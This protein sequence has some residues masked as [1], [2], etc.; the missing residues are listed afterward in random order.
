MSEI[1][2]KVVVIGDSTV[3]KTSIIHAYKNETVDINQGAT[4]G[5]ARTDFEKNLN[6]QKIILDVYDTAGQERYRSLGPIY[7]RDARYAIAVCDLTR[8][9]TLTSL[10]TWIQV[11]RESTED[12]FV[13]V[14][15]NK[16]DLKDEIK[17]SM[18]TLTQFAQ[19]HDAQLF[20]T[21]AVTGEGIDS[22]FNYLFMHFSNIHK[23]SEGIKLS[24]T[25]KSK[26]DPCC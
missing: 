13:Y 23:G 20:Y 25:K 17:I 9:E 26:N 24:A 3:G 1:H 12:S 7:Y 4:V 6:G 15:A 21:S 16:C 11:F 22:V 5:F 8:T 19:D 2:A 10:D 14:V 18:D